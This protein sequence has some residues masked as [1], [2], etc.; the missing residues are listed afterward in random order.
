MY[1]EILLIQLVRYEHFLV[2]F[3]IQNENLFDKFYFFEAGPRVKSAFQVSHL[4]NYVDLVE[5]PL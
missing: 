1:R 3:N 4:Q 2:L 5:L